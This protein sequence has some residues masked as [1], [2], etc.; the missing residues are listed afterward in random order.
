[1]APQNFVGAPESLAVSAAQ[2]GLGR[3][4]LDHLFSITYE[5]LRR[6]AYSVKRGDP[7][8]TLSPTTLVNEAWLR[9]AESPA[10][11]AE[12]L[13]HFKRI[14]GRAMRQLL[15]EAARRRHSHKRG[16]NG[17][18]IFVTFDES[19]KGA[20]TGG[21][22]LLAL[23]AALTELGHLEP[24][25]AAI[26]EARFFGGLEISEISTLVGVS[27]ATILRDWRAA[28]A[29]LGQRLRRAGAGTTEE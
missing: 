15:I 6:L 9:L 21:Q 7:S 24:R 4:A 25:Q 20:V 10:I 3:Q 29:W 27:E 13:L 5:E 11:K 12:S 1:M 19:L 22:D 17:S 18:A 2:G 23:D 14:A 8:N 16:G 28:K 26:V